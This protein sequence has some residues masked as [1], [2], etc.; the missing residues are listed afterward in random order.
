PITSILLGA[1]FYLAGVAG[2]ALAWPVPLTGVLFYL[3]WINWILALFNLVPAFPLDGGRVLRAY[4]WSCDG[5]LRKATRTAANIGAAFGAWMVVLA[6][7]LVLQGNVIAGMWWFLIGLFLRSASQSSFQQVLI[8]R[9]LEG[10]AIR[11]FMTPAPVVVPPSLSLEEF[12]ENYIYRYHHEMFPVMAD[13]KL[14]GCVCARQVK[15]SPRSQWGELSVEELLTSPSKENTVRPDTD[16]LQVLS[17]MQRTG[18]SRFMVV[19][20]GQ[21]VGI[22]ASKDLL[23]FLALKLDLESD[24]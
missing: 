2:K 4:L 23:A 8:R 18:N 12:V 3:G 5:N 7:F 9:A 1:G 6:A 17:L 11:R 14:L 10:E 13:G 24:E 15:Q 21:L 22:V 20:G 16:S 19:E